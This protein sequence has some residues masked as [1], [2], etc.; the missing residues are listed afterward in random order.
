MEQRRCSEG[1][2]M[3]GTEIAIRRLFTASRD[4]KT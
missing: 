1:K 2:D 3:R 4:R